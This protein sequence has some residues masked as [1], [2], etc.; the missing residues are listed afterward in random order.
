MNLLHP[1]T[2]FQPRVDGKLS[3]Q[4]EFRCCDRPGMHVKP[5]SGTHISTVPH[6]DVILL[7]FPAALDGRSDTLC[8]LL[9][10]IFVEIRGLDVRWRTSVG[11]VE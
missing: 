10:V 2:K 9:S 8:I 5:W 1:S 7:V 3:P 4:S 11:V 6:L